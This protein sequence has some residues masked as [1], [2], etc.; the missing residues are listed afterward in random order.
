VDALPIGE[1]VW[2]YFELNNLDVRVTELQA[3]TIV[4]EE[5]PKDKP[6]LWREARLKDPDGNQLVLYSAGVNRVNPP[7]RIY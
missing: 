3:A 2:V 6:W 7:W 5:L 4:F 1:G